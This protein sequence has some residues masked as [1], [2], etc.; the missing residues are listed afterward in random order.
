MAEGERQPDEL[1]VR[2]GDSLV[3]RRAGQSA[4][5]Q[6]A[7]ERTAAPVRTALARVLGVHTDERAWRKGA[8]GERVIGAELAKLDKE[9]WFVFH[10]IPIGTQG[11]N[12]DHLVIGPAGVFTINTKNT[13]GKLWVGERAILQN[14]HKTDWLPMARSEAQRAGKLLAAAVGIPVDVTPV[15]AVIYEDITVRPF[16]RMSSSR[17][18]ERSAS[19]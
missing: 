12:V 10:D 8:A 7:A 15:L 3:R 1:V 5:D 16:L 17:A 14:G 13:T 11:A 2:L 6:A 18:D 19:G 9:R 4:A